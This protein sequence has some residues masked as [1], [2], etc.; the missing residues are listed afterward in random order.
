MF[1]PVAWYVEFQDDAVMNQTVDGD[2]GGQRVLEDRFPFGE[3]STIL[4]PFVALAIEF[5]KY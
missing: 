3:A 4:S 1:K 5:S 2:R